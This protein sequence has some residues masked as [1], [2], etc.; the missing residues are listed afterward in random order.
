MPTRPRPL[1]PRN[2]HPPIQPYRQTAS[3]PAR[4]NYPDE[5]ARAQARQARPA[6]GLPAYSNAFDPT[7]RFTAPGG[8][9]FDP[10]RRFAAGGADQIPGYNAPL[11]AGPY[12]TLN[13]PLQKAPQRFN[14]YLPP[15]LS[16]IFSTLDPYRQYL[17]PEMTQ[18]MDTLR[19]PAASDLPACMGR[20]FGKLRLPQFGAPP[21][22]RGAVRGP[23]NYPGR[24][25]GPVNP[26]YQ[27]VEPTAPAAAPDY[28]EAAYT[29]NFGPDYGAGGQGGGYGGYGGGGGGGGGG[30]PREL[31]PWYYG[32][33]SWRF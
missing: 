9:A 12:D 4:Y 28:G 25:T 13:T 1:P 17:P 23:S 11:P 16:K 6:T 27:L 18:V 14:P 3:P 24:E 2:P 21:V 10:T 5:S 26:P 33:I 31:P 22:K 32:L 8:N 30:A 20:E 29:P 7:R 15:E 19:S